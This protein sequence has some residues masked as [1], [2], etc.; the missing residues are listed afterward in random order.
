MC[1]VFSLFKVYIFLRPKVYISCYIRVTGTLWHSLGHSRDPHTYPPDNN[2]LSPPLSY[3]TFLIPHY[4]KQ[5]CITLWRLLHY[6]V[7]TYMRREAP[8]LCSRAVDGQFFH[9]EVSPLPHEVTFLCVLFWNPQGFE[10]TQRQHCCLTS[11]LY[12]AETSQTL[13]TTLMRLY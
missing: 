7:M 1:Y 10:V 8:F 2:H 3:Y 6:D 9:F 11:T 13:C 12:K 5:C 4:T